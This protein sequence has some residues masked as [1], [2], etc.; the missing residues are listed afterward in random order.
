MHTQH[1]TLSNTMQAKQHGSKQTPLPI[2]K[3][4][5]NVISPSD[6]CD[7]NVGGKDTFLGSTFDT[8][9]DKK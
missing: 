1:S 8:S 7:R 4:R 2:H 9:S 6:L 5:F 3:H